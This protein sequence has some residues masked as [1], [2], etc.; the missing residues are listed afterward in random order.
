VERSASRWMVDSNTARR[1]VKT[2]SFC[3]RCRSS[4]CG[5]DPKHAS[6]QYE[7]RAIVPKQTRVCDCRATLC[8]VSSNWRTCGRRS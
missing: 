7:V 8:P 6:M 4:T 2:V 5:R 1:A 3:L